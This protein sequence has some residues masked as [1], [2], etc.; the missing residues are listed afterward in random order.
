MHF[1]TW[2]DYHCQIV[3]QVVQWGN[4]VIVLLLKQYK[5]S[6]EKDLELLYMCMCVCVGCPGSSLLHTGFLFWL[7]SVGASLLC[8]AGSL[9]A[10]VSCGAWLLGAQAQ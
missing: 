6:L 3:Q 2:F 9:I 10:V 8:G 5:E 4:L 1:D 7:W